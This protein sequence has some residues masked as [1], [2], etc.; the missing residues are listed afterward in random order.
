MGALVN[1]T[2]RRFDNDGCSKQPSFGVEGSKA[3]SY[4]G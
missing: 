3:A 4:C 1:V 2:S